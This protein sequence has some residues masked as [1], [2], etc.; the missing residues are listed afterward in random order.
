MNKTYSEKNG[1]F[2]LSAGVGVLEGYI[3]LFVL[4]FISA[5]I[6]TAAKLTAGAAV[7][8]ATVSLCAAGLFAGVVSSKKYGSRVLVMGTVTGL[9]FYISVALISVIITRS[10]LSSLFVWRLILTVAASSIGSVIG[11]LKQSNKKMI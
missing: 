1:G 11:A 3:A 2:M 6:M 10:G 9:A 8:M 4:L 7:I 5:I